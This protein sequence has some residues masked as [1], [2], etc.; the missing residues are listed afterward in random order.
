MEKWWEFMT[1][2]EKEKYARDRVIKD[3]KCNIL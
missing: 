1:N 2:R 3:N